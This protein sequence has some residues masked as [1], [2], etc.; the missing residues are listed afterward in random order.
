MQSLTIQQL[1]DIEQKRAVI[2]L[3]VEESIPP[4][5]DQLLP[6]LTEIVIGE[7]SD[8]IEDSLDW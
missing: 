7:I 1:Q 8:G 5:L 3:V 6:H 4:H 2:Q